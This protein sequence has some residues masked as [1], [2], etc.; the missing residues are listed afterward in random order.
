MW[1]LNEFT[2]LYS[3]K[4]LILKDVDSLKQ[5]L[6]HKNTSILMGT[7]ACWSNSKLKLGFVTHENSF[8]FPYTIEG[9][10]F[11]KKYA[12]GIFSKEYYMIKAKIKKLKTVTPKT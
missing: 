3:C 10:G 8:L 5:D 1:L 4:F 6:D 11:G 12:I 7:L 9:D 2:I